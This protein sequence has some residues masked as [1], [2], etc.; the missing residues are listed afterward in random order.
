MG[1]RCKAVIS[2]RHSVHDAMRCSYPT[3]RGAAQP[4]SA[5]AA[6]EEEGTQV[7]TT[8]ERAGAQPPGGGRT[9]FVRNATGLM[10]SVGSVA[11]RHVI[12]RHQLMLSLH[13]H[14]HESRGAVKIGKTLCINPG[15]AYADGILQGALIELNSR[16]GIKSYQLPAGLRPPNQAAGCLVRWP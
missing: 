2:V 8:G 12:E 6:P 1:R 9:L 15:S 13:G 4:V 10:E 14:I 16:K 11:V 5:P 3:P 7:T